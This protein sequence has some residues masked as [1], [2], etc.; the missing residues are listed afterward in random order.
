VGVPV[1]YMS[2][3]SESMA[4][5]PLDDPRMQLLLK[6]FTVEELGRRVRQILDQVQ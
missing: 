3:Y 4:G 1:L 6:P 5:M 2:G